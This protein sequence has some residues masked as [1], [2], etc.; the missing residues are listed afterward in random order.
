MMMDL[1]T[2]STSM[3]APHV[4]IAGAG[5][6]G[7][8]C[9]IL[10]CR[11]GISVT[12]LEK[13]LGGNPWSAKSYSINLN[14][15]GLTSLE[16]AGVLDEAKSVGMARHRFV[17]ENALTGEQQQIPRDPPQYGF[18]RPGLVE[19]LETFLQKHYADKV[20]IHRGVSVQ[21]IVIHRRSKEDT[22]VDKTSCANDD[23]DNGKE[24]TISSVDVILDNGS[25]ITCTHVIGA[26]GKWSAVRNA[27]PDFNGK[28]QI[29]MEPTWGIS[30][31]PSNTPE[32][33]HCDALNVF[34]P[35]AKDSK[36]YIIAAPLPPD[37][38][39]SATTA[40]QQQQQQQYSISIICFD[41][42]QQ[43]HPWLLPREDQ[44]SVL[45]WYEYGSRTAA[46][47]TDSVFQQRL[48]NLLQ[49]DVPLF[50]KDLVGDQ[51]KFATSVRINRR[52][53]WLKATSDHPQYCDSS[54]RIALVGD[55]AHAMTP[56]IG[57]G[58]NCAL[59]SAV[60]LIQSLISTTTS[61]K[62]QLQNQ[63][64]IITVEDLTRAILEYG[65]KRPAQVI[66]FQER[67]AAGNRYQQPEPSKTNGK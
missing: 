24:G 2:S 19:C 29:Q 44:D 28:F 35:A 20:T 18:T 49:N 10:L 14:E 38:H 36:Y 1:A 34:R 23:S 32:R 50:H 63:E 64:T 27:V 7:L 56:S 4:A 15:R 59:E 21:D 48:S 57:E 41:E 22:D 55:A 66:P 25:K 12:L 53:S 58:C 46:S 5:P 67:S 11:L 33:W 31:T 61:G 43:D 52:V 6:V 3:L 40:Q 39:K 51:Q 37:H 60:S 26:D 16:Y 42:I 13:S 17:M 8:L 65:T 9:A 30:I 62:K 54:G 47:E 45:D